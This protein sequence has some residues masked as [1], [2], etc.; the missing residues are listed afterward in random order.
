M[1]RDYRINIKASDFSSKDEIRYFKKD[2][3]HD[4]TKKCKRKNKKVCMRNNEKDYILTFTK[5]ELYNAVITCGMPFFYLTKNALVARSN[6]ILY[7]IFA[8]NTAL[9]VDDEGFLFC[10]DKMEYLDKTE[11]GLLMYYVGMFITKL[12]SDKIF[13][14]DYLVH[15]S[16]ASR[17]KSIKYNSNKEPDFVAFNIANNNCSIFEAKGLSKMDKRTLRNGKAQARVIKWFQGTKPLNHIVSLSHP[18]GSK[19]KRLLCRL[20]DPIGNEKYDLDISKLE[21]IWLYY[22]PIFSILQ[23]KKGK[24]RN[25]LAT[26]LTVSQ[27]ESIEISMDPELYEILETFEANNRSLSYLEKDDQEYLEKL[28]RIISKTNPVSIRINET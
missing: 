7:K 4:I 15:L 25:A 23:E 11:R 26:T 10:S 28:Q 5:N 8:I 21:L 13:C 1:T 3:M 14:F 16:I 22:E 2:C 24:H 17:Y 9:D 6:D 27:N 12:V 19:D 20:K 18:I